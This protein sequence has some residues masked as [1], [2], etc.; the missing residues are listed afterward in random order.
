MCRPA[1]SARGA[2][3]A[4]WHLH[5]ERE[6]AAA[7]SLRARALVNAAG[8]WAERCSPTTACTRTAAYG[9]RLI[10][11]SHIVVPRLHDGEQAY[12]LQHRDGRIVFVIPWLQRFSL[13]GTTDREY[14]GDPGGGARSARRKSTTCSAVVNEHFRRQ[15]GRNDILSHFSGVRPLYDDASGEP[16]AITR[17]Y[18]LVLAGAHGRTPRCCRCS[19]AS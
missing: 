10:Q 19:A 17:D 6:T 13:I 8:P 14:H 1:A 15:I 7:V 16:A 9:I 11:G 12:I 2:A 18:R 5:L 4:L 3:R